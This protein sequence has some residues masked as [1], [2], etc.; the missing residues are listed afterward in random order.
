[1]HSRDGREVDSIELWIDCA[2]LVWEQNGDGLESLLGKW[3]VLLSTAW[4]SQLM[5]LW[6]VSLRWPQ[7]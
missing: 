4:G 2:R 5:F 3:V 6:G 7:M 1:M